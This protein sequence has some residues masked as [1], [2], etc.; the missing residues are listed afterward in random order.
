MAD[1]TP[2]GGSDAARLRAAQGYARLSDP[3]AADI[4]GVSVTQYQRFKRGLAVTTPEQR[5]ALADATGV[6]PWFMD[7]GFE[8]PVAIREDQAL[9]RIAALERQVTLLLQREGARGGLAPPGA[10]DR[11]GEDPRRTGASPDPS[12]YPAA[13]D[14]P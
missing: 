7:H 10:G 5:L 2:P 14:S 1:T 11:R 12:E 9:G 6:P 8:P 3:D 13:E 4:L